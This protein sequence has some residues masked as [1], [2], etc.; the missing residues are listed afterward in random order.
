MEINRNDT[1]NLNAT[2]EIK[3]DSE[4]YSEKVENVLK[5]Y[6]KQASLPGFR[7]G[8][9]PAGVIK[10]RYGL[11]V[12][13]DEVQKLLSDS[14]AM[15]I[16]ENNLHILGEPLPRKDEKAIDWQ[17]QTSFRFSF[18]IG[19]A[20]E[21]EANISPKDKIPYYIIKVDNK[22]VDEQ[23]EQFA[24]QHG[25][26]LDVEVI[27]DFEELLRGDFTELDET[28]NMKEE[29]ITANDAMLLLSMIK[30][31]DIQNLFSGKQKGDAIVFN[32]MKALP[33]AKDIGLMLGI[34]EEQAKN[35]T[36]D[37]RFTINSISGFEPAE[38]NEELF[39]K[40]YG[41]E[42]ETEKEFRSK[43][44][45]D[46]GK[47]YLQE[48]DYKFS[49]DVKEKYLDKIKIELPVEFLKRWLIESDDEKNLTSEKVD[50]EFPQFEKQIKWQ[51][52]KDK[53]IK[54]NDLKVTQ[55]EIENYAKLMV[56]NYFKQ[57]GISYVPDDQLQTYAQEMLQKDEKRRRMVDNL[58]ENKA[59][60][61]IKNTVK[62]DKKEVSLEKFKELI[63]K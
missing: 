26:S 23:I 33:N 57:Y 53:I 8:K 45:E 40:M 44:K 16:S 39:K 34:E 2:I 19:L 43:L 41:E 15:Y 21:F 4:D 11:A 52:I 35:L 17:N 51:L 42:I 3:V 28:G 31:K 50:E 6:R 24:K 30:D 14:L 18:D 48:S 22:M 55:E 63:K 32:P 46:I 20:P 60:E 47:S 61:F 9:V 12:L 37:F 54:E 13:V 59:I 49:E 56:S 38:I 29:G 7:P 25:K 5:D 1:D 27:S 58:A 36:S 62:L 10:K